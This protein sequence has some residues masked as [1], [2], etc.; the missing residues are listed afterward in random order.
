MYN[1]KFFTIPD[2]LNCIMGLQNISEL[3]NMWEHKPPPIVY[4]SPYREI[5][6]ECN[7]TGIVMRILAG[8]YEVMSGDQAPYIET[9]DCVC[10]LSSLNEDL[11]VYECILDCPVPVNVNDSLH[12]HQRNSHFQIVSIHDGQTDI[13][14]ISID[15]SKWML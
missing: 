2:P 5:P 4:S 1:Y 15:I 9:N 3:K 8:A 14:L 11:S 6:L 7:G 13:T 10:N 12:V